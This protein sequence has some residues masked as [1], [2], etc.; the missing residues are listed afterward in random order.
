MFDNM[1]ICFW[2]WSIFPDVLTQAIHNFS[3]PAY[4]LVTIDQK[5]ILDKVVKFSVKYLTHETI[6][7]TDEHTDNILHL[8]NKNLINYILDY[9]KILTAILVPRTH[10]DTEGSNP[11]YAGRDEIKVVNNHQQMYLYL[12]D[13]IDMYLKLE[14]LDLKNLENE[15]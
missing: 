9:M 11:Y 2:N 4:C 7:K 12:E 6:I 14:W 13:V 10:N 1:N 15:L 5:P 3:S 8:L